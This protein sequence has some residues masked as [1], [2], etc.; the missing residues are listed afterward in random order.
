MNI[1]DML[2]QWFKLRF[3]ILYPFFAFAIFFGSP[4]DKSLMAGIW[5]IL[6]GLAIRLWANGY[7]VKLE[8]LTTCG[9]YAFVRHPL[10]LGTMIVVI[11]FIVVLKSY[12]I[13]MACFL[14]MAAVYYQTIKKEEK[15]LAEKFKNLYADYKRKVPAIIPAVFPYRG[16]EKWAF[17]RERLIR[18]REYKTVLWV[19]IL[20][21]VFYVKGRLTT[22]HKAIDAKAAAL[23]IIA[24]I[25]GSVDLISE[26]I[27]SKNKR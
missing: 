16:S 18:S 19:L 14:V 20:V 10:Y 5:F 9:P 17:S 11:G 6:S 26:F 1:K 8:R 4:D 3:A 23:I 27:E 25:S 24:F 22:E 13:G 15:M 7:A 2:K 21:V 12:Y